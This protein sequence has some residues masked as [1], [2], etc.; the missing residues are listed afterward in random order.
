MSPSFV[1]LAPAWASLAHKIIFQ[2]PFNKLEPFV[3]GIT[4]TCRFILCFRSHTTHRFGCRRV[5]F[6]G[7]TENLLSSDPSLKSELVSASLSS[8]CLNRFTTQHAYANL[9]LLR[10]CVDEMWWKTLTF[11]SRNE[12]WN[13][14]GESDAVPIC[15][16]YA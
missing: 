16:C 10:H 11:Y 3:H 6:G 5:L 1:Y 8:R 12:L 2:W 4:V 7:K 9:G 14:S 15:M 13:C